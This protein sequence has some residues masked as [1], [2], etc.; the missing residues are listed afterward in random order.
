MHIPKRWSTT[1]LDATGIILQRTGCLSVDTAL[2]WVSAQRV[3]KEHVALVGAGDSD[4][5]WPLRS[6]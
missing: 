3:A 4:W 6:C 5:L 1:D 2:G